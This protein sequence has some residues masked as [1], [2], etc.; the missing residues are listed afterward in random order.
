[1]DVR[2]GS[3]NVCA[4]LLAGDDHVRHVW[5]SNHMLEW[6]H[7][8]VAAR[9]GEAAMLWQSET[10]WV[11]QVLAD[12][13]DT[14]PK[15]MVGLRLLHQ[16]CPRTVDMA[17]NTHVSPIAQLRVDRDFAMLHGRKEC[18][19]VEK[20]VGRANSCLFVLVPRIGGEQ[21]EVSAPSADDDDEDDD[22][23]GDIDW[24]EGDE[25]EAQEA[26]ATAVEQTLAVMEATGRLKGGD[27]EVSL[28]G[29]NDNPGPTASAAAPSTD[30]KNSEKLV[31]ART[32][33]E[34][35]S[36]SLSTRHMKRLTS[37]LHAL[38]NAD[39]LI[40]QPGSSSL[41]AM[42]KNQVR[43]I[44]E[45][46]NR[47]LQLKTAVSSILASAN[48]LSIVAPTEDGSAAPEA[49]APTNLTNV[50]R[51]H[52]NLARSMQRR[53]LGGAGS[54]SMQR[55]NRIQVKYRR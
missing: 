4:K 51:R 26:H 31:L 49:R 6:L 42:S 33:L 55:S 22:L 17:S 16:R 11:L 18:E 41:V 7:S 39:H 30:D 47:L 28:Q 3:L 2:R 14:E 29:D 34:R 37:W 25:Q 46:R 36:K 10:K 21:D 35:I 54:T 50:P 12:T 19:I 1:M 45:L 24:E 20:L 38:S 52:E 40:Q 5:T 53:R 15:Y 32:K 9:N 8:V 44:A 23:D 13:Y 43:D 48:K 27:L